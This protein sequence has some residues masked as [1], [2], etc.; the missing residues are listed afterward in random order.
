[1][2]Y[3]IQDQDSSGPSFVFVPFHSNDTAY[4]WCN[5]CDVCLALLSHKH[6]QSR[7]LFEARN[8]ST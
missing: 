1:M 4:I 2:R 5:Q 3:N 8:L 7:F 6:S